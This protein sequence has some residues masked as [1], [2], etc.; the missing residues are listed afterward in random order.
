MAGCVAADPGGA[1]RDETTSVEQA[2]LVAPDAVPTAATA[3]ALEAFLSAV[4]EKR[5]G[6]DDDGLH[7]SWHYSDAPAL[8][9]GVGKRIPFSTFGCAQRDPVLRIRCFFD[10][11]RALWGLDPAE[12]ALPLV[13]TTPLRDGRVV[14]RFRQRLSGVPVAGADVSATLSAD[15][16]AITRVY[17]EAVRG[18]RLAVPEAEVTS[19][20]FPSPLPAAVDRAVASAVGPYAVR[21]TARLVLLVDETG[22]SL[23]ARPYWYFRVADAAGRQR[24]VS[25]DLGLREAPVVRP[26]AVEAPDPVPAPVKEYTEAAYPAYAGSACFAAGPLSTDCAAHPG[27]NEC[28]GQGDGT[29]YLVQSCTD[30]C[31]AACWEGWTCSAEEKTA[32]LCLVPDEWDD[33]IG[34]GKLLFDST[35]GGWQ[36]PYDQIIPMSYLQ[37]SASAWSQFMADWLHRDGGWNLKGDASSATV[38]VLLKN[39]LDPEDD[40]CTASAWGGGGSVEVADWSVFGPWTLDG[41]DWLMGHEGAHSITGYYMYISTQAAIDAGETYIPSGNEDC[42][43]ENWSDLLGSVFSRTQHQEDAMNAVWRDDR[44]GLAATNARFHLPYAQRSRYDFA[45]CSGAYPAVWTA[46]TCTS[47]ADCPMYQGCTKPPKGTFPDNLLRCMAGGTHFN[48]IVWS[49]LGRLLAEGSVALA[50]DGTGEDLG[51]EQGIT[52]PGV[53][54][55]TAVDILYEAWVQVT[56]KTSQLRLAELI[57]GAASAYGTE[58]LRQTRYSLG[59]VGFPGATFAM[60]VATDAAP[61]GLTW[62][63]WGRS[64]SNIRV[65]YVYKKAGATDIGVRYHEGTA[66]KEHVITANTQDTPAAIAYDGNLH[67]FWRDAAS[68]AVKVKRLSTTG[69]WSTVQDLSGLGLRAAGAFDAAIYKSR[70]Y[71]GFV[72]PGTTTL[73]LAWCTSI[74][75]TGCSNAAADWHPY[76][77]GVFYKD[78]LKS[79]TSGVALDAGTAVN[80]T[81]GG[82]NLFALLSK[83]AVGPGNGLLYV[84]RIGNDDLVLDERAIPD[85]L[86]SRRADPDIARGLVVRKSAFGGTDPSH[87]ALSATGPYVYL[88]W[89]DSGTPRLYTAVVQ[90]WGSS[91]AT[92]M[93]TR[94]QIM[95]P[96]RSGVVFWRH[97]SEIS[98]RHAFATTDDQGMYTVVWTRY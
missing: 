27:T 58:A 24:Q 80:G 13:A 45:A 19:A 73:H 39:C 67:V 82:E 88:T 2:A 14:Y 77:G 97:D 5:A 48:G 23:D 91:S 57:V 50:A 98:A 76:P 55:A 52:W 10:R 47:D 22:G 89:N 92:A 84:V 85:L 42:Q 69:V 34:W 95:G 56:H 33:A 51:S 65:F 87:T 81:G 3:R 44:N 18:I 93:I 7:V 72:R 1:A 12:A 63:G 6:S 64:T 54:L 61:R 21:T 59:G 49:R 60:G 32:G 37:A 53:G 90:D 46:L 68:N 15:G 40:E 36:G 71:L 41:G 20:R 83:V 11:N 4:R 16:L 43:N 74:D 62:F 26:V 31:G 70:L 30:P 35:A 25:I 86:A 78:L 9:W 66:W 29:A 96:A 28:V 79:T 94:P 17:S 38:A 8:L 75:G